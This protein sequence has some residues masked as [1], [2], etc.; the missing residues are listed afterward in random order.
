PE[1]LI[2][3]KKMKQLSGKITELFNKSIVTHL[4]ILDDIKESVI[5]DKRVL[6]VNSAMRKRVKGKFLGTS[7]TGSIS[8]IELESVQNPQ[9]ELDEVKEEEKKEIIKILRNLTAIISVYKPLLED[10][11]KLLEYLDFTQA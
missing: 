1:L 9:R 10:Y 3:R 6:A 7:K 5:D 2:F 4:N 8:F 11:D